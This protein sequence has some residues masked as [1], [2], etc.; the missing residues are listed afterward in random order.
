M[1]CQGCGSQ[2]AEG[3]KYCKNCGG[4][5]GRDE[6]ENDSSPGKMLDTILDTLFWFGMVGL[7][8]LIGLVAVLLSKGVPTETVGILATGYLAV[9][10]V[11]CFML[12]RQIPKLVD[13]KLKRWSGNEDAAP[14]QLSSRTTAQLDEYREP[15]MSVTDHTTRTL[16]KVP[17]KGK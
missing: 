4:R 2:V 16:N 10:F 9:I 5:L 11:I 14:A 6:A 8:I 13:A 3:L 7:G 17:A 15:V 1:Y 12:A